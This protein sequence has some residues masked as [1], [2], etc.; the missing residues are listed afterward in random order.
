MASRE[1]PVDR[2]FVVAVRSR[3]INN[4]PYD[5]YRL[6]SSFDPGSSAFADLRVLPCD[7][8]LP[9]SREAYLFLET[10]GTWM[11]FD[12][13]V[14]RMAG[15]VSRLIEG[16]GPLTVVG[17]QAG[18]LRESLGI[19]FRIVSSLSFETIIHPRMQ[20]REFPL[21]PACIEREEN[22]FY[23]GERYDGERYELATTFSIFHSM[24]CPNH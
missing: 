8:A 21:A 17:P 16:H 9:A 14:P 11:C 22:R 4:T 12:W 7:S 24:N 23:N 3:L 10:A 20:G 15:A 6:I 2:L 19:R 5:V 1:H 13:D 18:A